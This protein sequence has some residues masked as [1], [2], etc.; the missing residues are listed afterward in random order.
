MAQPKVR[1]YLRVISQI[2]A[3]NNVRGAKALESQIDRE[4]ND[5]VVLTGAAQD[6]RVVAV[7]TVDH[8]GGVYVVVTREGKTVLTAT[9]PELGETLPATCKLGD[10]GT[11]AV[12]V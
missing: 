9:L 1:G 5:C 4:A 7:L 12:Q 8:K 3:L 2:P 6:G 11:L 10:A